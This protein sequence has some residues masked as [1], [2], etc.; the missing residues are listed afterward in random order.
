MKR[1]PDDVGEAFIGYQKSLAWLS[2]L[3]QLYD[4]SVWRTKAY[5]SGHFND[6]PFLFDW[7]GE[8][9]MFTAESFSGLVRRPVVLGRTDELTPFMLSSTEPETRDSACVSDHVDA[10]K[11]A[12]AVAAA[13]VC[14]TN[15]ATT[16]TRDDRSR[17]SSNDVCAYEL[18][19][20][21]LYFVTK[22]G[23]LDCIHSKAM[24]WAVNKIAVEEEFDMQLSDEEAME[25][26]R[27]RLLERYPHR[28]ATLDLIKLYRSA[29]CTGQLFVVGDD[30]GSPRD[31]DEES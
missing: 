8:T 24:C 30:R 9:L 4:P 26:L 21:Q 22:D 11:P 20:D 10:E 16:G 6:R 29:G 1:N 15:A 19:V 23:T 31:P 2:G 13:S 27:Q 17:N 12:A 3:Q 25:N 18:F 7:N 14:D 28:M 5:P